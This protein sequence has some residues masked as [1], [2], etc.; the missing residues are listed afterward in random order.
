MT[1]RDQDAQKIIK[2]I[3]KPKENKKEK[4][5]IK[6]KQRGNNERSQSL[7]QVVVNA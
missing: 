7:N 1:E 5:A 2:H 6:R 3:G 4:I